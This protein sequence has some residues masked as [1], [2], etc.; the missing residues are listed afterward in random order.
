RDSRQPPA[1]RRR[2]HAA[3]R[4]PH[5]RRGERVTAFNHLTGTLDTERHDL[6]AV[7]TKACDPLRF[8]DVEI[9]HATFELLMTETLQCLPPAVHPS[10]PGHLSLLVVRSPA[11][12]FGPLS[13]AQIRV[14]CRAGLER[15]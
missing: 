13:L 6:P 5:S 4:R 12:P 10:I 9:V 15:R 8:D 7:T 11:G 3:L 14:G 2:G 1:L